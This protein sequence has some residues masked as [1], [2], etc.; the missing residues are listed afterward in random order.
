MSKLCLKGF[1]T[2]AYKGAWRGL[3]DGTEADTTWSPR[4]SPMHVLQGNPPWAC[5]R[6]RHEL[7]H[8]ILPWSFQQLGRPVGNPPYHPDGP[9]W[10]AGLGLRHW[11]TYLV[12]PQQ[13][14]NINFEL[15]GLYVKE[16]HLWFQRS[17]EKWLLEGDLNTSYFHRVANGRKQKKY[18]GLPETK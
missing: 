18:F 10:L 13:K 15:F 11:Y 6:I 2:P 4:L 8:P 12:Y 7:L 17:H 1:S 9:L 3:H 14:S 5:P 16:E